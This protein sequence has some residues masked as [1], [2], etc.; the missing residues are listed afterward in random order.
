MALLSRTSLREA[1]VLKTQSF[2]PHKFG[3][4][5]RSCL[6]FSQ[7]RD[8]DNKIRASY[9]FYFE[10]IPIFDYSDFTGPSSTVQK[11]LTIMF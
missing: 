5:K 2:D 6:K 9:L 4:I 1:K 7:L 8:V 11:S 10:T 3:W